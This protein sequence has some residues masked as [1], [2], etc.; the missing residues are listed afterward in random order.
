MLIFL[1]E[2]PTELTNC[3]FPFIEEEQENMWKCHDT[4][5][6]IGDDYAL[7]QFLI[8]LKLYIADLLLLALLASLSVTS[9]LGP[10]SL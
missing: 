3:L 2:P 10:N 9:P 4:L 5:G 8:L 7:D 6:Q 1:S